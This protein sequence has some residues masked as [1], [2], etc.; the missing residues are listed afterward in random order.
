MKLFCPNF[1]QFLYLRK[2]DNL[3]AFNYLSL[4]ICRYQTGAL[5]PLIRWMSRGMQRAAAPPQP[6]RPADGAN[7]IPAA[8]RQ[9]IENAA[10]AGICVPAISTN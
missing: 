8:A 7:N 1:P 10:L 6:P 3:N 9:G 2:Y 5:A 4:V